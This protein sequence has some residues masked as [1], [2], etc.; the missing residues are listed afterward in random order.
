MG[1]KKDQ[2]LNHLK[3]SALYQSDN[4]AY[5]PLPS[6]IT[7]NVIDGR[8]FRDTEEYDNAGIHFDEDHGFTEHVYSSDSKRGN[9][10]VIDGKADTINHQTLGEQTASWANSNKC[11]RSSLNE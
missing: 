10:D 5:K 11:T 7:P 8:P 9:T 2:A 1:I 3:N 4:G 6:G